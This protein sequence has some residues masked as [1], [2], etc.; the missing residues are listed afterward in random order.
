M[1]EI[2][3]SMEIQHLFDNKLVMQNSDNKSEC[4]SNYQIMTENNFK[5][6]IK[7]IRH[8]SNK[9]IFRVVS[10]LSIIDVTEDHSLLDSNGNELKPQDSL[11]K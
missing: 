10:D 5:N 2:Y 9:K 8:K 6:I 3:K 11:G 7:V 4:L 1:N